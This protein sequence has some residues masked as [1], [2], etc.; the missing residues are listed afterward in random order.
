[1]VVR[2]GVSRL[3]KKLETFYIQ[4]LKTIIKLRSSTPNCMIYSEV[5][6]LPFQVTVYKQT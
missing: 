1:M 2:F 5:G 6:K 4:F 3:T